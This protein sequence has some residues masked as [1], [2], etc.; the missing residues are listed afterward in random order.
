MQIQARANDIP[1]YKRRWGDRIGFEV[2]VRPEDQSR[3]NVLREVRE[4]VDTYAKGGGFFSSVAAQDPETAWDAV[5][6]LYYYSREKYDEEQG[7]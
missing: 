1:A 4:T 3:E 7:R 2:A 5:M 6:E